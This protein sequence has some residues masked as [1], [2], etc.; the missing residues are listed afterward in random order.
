[1][2]KKLRN[3]EINFCTWF[4]PSKNEENDTCIINK[5]NIAHI[6]IV[7]LESITKYSFHINSDRYS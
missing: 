5:R 6:N 7:N 2:Q 3:K 4:K 1:M